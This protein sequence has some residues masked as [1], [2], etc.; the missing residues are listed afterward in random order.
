M[1]T[2]RVFLVLLVAMALIV[3]CTMA[4]RLP[5]A[6]PET[7][8]IKSTTDIKCIGD[9]LESQTLTQAVS[10]KNNIYNAPLSKTEVVSISSYSQNVMSVNANAK[11]TNTLSVDTD[12]KPLDLNNVDSITQLTVNGGRTTM[13][14]GIAV[15]VVGKADKTEEIM[16]CP[17]GEAKTEEFPP[18][19]DISR[20]GGYVDLASGSVATSTGDRTVAAIADVPLT[21]NYK[22]SVIGYGTNP[23]AIGSA[24]AYMDVH[25]LDA[26][27]ANTKCHDDI[28]PAA[29]LQYNGAEYV[30]G[31]FT[32]VQAYEY[33]S[34]ILI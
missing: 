2:K 28:T 5:P 17:F 34:G 11:Y 24:G 25:A 8:T 1:N 19:C 32:F 26:R 33:T 22:I 3:G 16:L 30:N 7:Q 10:S 23:Y 31:Q 4:A 13:N 21:A 18:F 15:D 20:M 6:T 29:E 27:D 12:N 14:E 9:V